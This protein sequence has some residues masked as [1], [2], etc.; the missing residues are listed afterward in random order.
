MQSLLSCLKKLN[1]NSNILSSLPASP[2]PSDHMFSFSLLQNH[3]AVNFILRH[4][5]IGYRLTFQETFG[6]Q[7]LKISWENGK[8]GT[9]CK[10]ADFRDE[11]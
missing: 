3:L 8:V 5:K 7:A 11:G 2:A 10:V 6:F 4:Q 1:F 9:R